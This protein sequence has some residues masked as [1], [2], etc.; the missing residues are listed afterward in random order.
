MA[1]AVRAANLERAADG[2]L[3]V[4]PTVAM[5]HSPRETGLFSWT[6]EAL[7]PAFCVRKTQRNS[8]RAMRILLES[9]RAEKGM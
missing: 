9:S 1:L 8:H 4:T 6:Y 2:Y 3:S 7:T 5:R